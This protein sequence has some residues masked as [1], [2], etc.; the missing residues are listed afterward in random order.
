ML[1]SVGRH[2]R[3]PFSNASEGVVAHLTSNNVASAL[4]EMRCATGQLAVGG[5]GENDN[6]L[7]THEGR[8]SLLAAGQLTTGFDAS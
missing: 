5:R 7:P 4:V 8:S 2:L 6:C 3:H 1:S